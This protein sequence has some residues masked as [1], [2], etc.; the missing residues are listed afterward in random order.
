MIISNAIITVSLIAIPLAL[1]LDY[2]LIGY[3]SHAELKQLLGLAA[4][5]YSSVL[6]NE[7]VLSVEV[8]FRNAMRE[9]QATHWMAPCKL[10]PPSLLPT[11]ERLIANLDHFIA[12]IQAFI[13]PRLLGGKTAVFSASGSLASDNERH[14]HLRAPFYRRIPAMIIDNQ[15][16]IHILL[17]F[18]NIAGAALC[19]IRAHCRFHDDPRDRAEYIF[20]RLGWP[21][22]LWF[23]FIFVC[24]GPVYYAI[25]PPNMP[26]REETLDRDPLTRIAYPKSAAKKLKW[27]WGTVGYEYYF[28][29]AVLYTVG[30]WLA[31]RGSPVHEPISSGSYA[32]K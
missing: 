9:I 13:L 31:A 4:L 24:A 26:A 10:Q 22:L 3:S 28:T 25:I 18:A 16:W 17:I 8:G 32:Q 29:I 23:V 11:A 27:T 15:L 14:R 5:A 6:V 7:I 19:L 1:L 30:T 2:P 21:P 12:L 20:I